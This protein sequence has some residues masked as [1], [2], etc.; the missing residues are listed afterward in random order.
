MLVPPGEGGAATLGTKRQF[1]DELARFNIATDG[2]SEN[3][4]VAF[5]PGFRLELPFIGDKDPVSQALIT[6]TEEDNAWPVLTRLCRE[7][8]WR[9]MDLDSGRTFGV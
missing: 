6:I 9:L 8:N 1:V 4:G 2:S 3:I 7:M 5:G